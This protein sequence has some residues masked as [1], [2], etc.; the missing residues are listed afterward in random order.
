MRQPSTFGRCFPLVSSNCFVGRPAGHPF[1]R[2]TPIRRR[3]S[4][5]RTPSPRAAAA[6]D[7]DAF[8]PFTCLFLP[9]SQATQLEHEWKSFAAALE[10]RS[11][12]L[13][14]SGSFHL[15][16]DT[17]LQSCVRWESTMHDLDATTV[18]E[19][20]EAVGSLQVRSSC[21]RV[22][23]LIKCLRSPPTFS[24]S[25]FPLSLGVVWRGE[26]DISDHTDRI[27][28]V[29]CTILVSFS[30]CLR[31]VVL[32]CAVVCC[33]EREREGERESN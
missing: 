26:V 31:R 25:R 16:A 21:C 10:D 28:I 6:V 30:L 3:R 2:M 22:C 33:V 9:P 7:D 18:A 8:P 19:L 14:L 4:R 15:R 27:R 13:R 11:H 12:V 17:Y 29:Q 24:N 32:C 23:C 1:V 5:Q 20:Q